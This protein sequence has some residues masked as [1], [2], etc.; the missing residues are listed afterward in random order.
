MSKL[1]STIIPKY[2]RPFSKRK[3]KLNSKK[4]E[5]ELCKKKSFMVISFSFALK[6]RI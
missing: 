5:L 2:L 3:L 4:V 6:A 1:L